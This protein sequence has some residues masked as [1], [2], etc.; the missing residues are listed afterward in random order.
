M[1][2]DGNTIDLT[3]DEG[4]FASL[5]SV[6]SELNRQLALSGNFEGERAL[7]VRVVDGYT[8]A[9]VTVPTDAN[10]YLVMENEF[11][12]AIEVTGN[13]SFFFGS[14]LNTITGSDK[15]LSSLGSNTYSNNTAGKIDGGVDTTADNDVEVR[16]DDSSGNSV[17]RQAAWL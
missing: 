15:I 4:D 8:A 10:R 3:M 6:A 5:E 13:A 1:D 17:T 9:N 11:G 12:K 7:N 2:N 14:Q 16:I